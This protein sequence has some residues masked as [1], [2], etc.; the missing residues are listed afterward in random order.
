MT[1]EIP[2]LKRMVEHPAL[3]GSSKRGRIMA[4]G[5]GLFAQKRYQAVTMEQVAEVA[6]VAKGTLY[7]Y[8]KSKE[9]LYLAILS[10]GLA[11]MAQ[12]YQAALDPTTDVQERLQRA[13]AVTIEF[14]QKRHNLLSLL[15]TEEPRLARARKRLIEPWRDR[16]MRHFQSLVAEGMRTGAFRPGDPQLASFA[17]MGAMRSVLLYYRTRRPASG[18]SAELAEFLTRALG[19]GGPASPQEVRGAR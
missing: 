18:I 1:A 6:G 14:Y 15:A 2:I 19:T 12:R 8:F 11:T 7:L 5:L 17:I 16:G 3:E 10:D 4:A 9:Q 13:I